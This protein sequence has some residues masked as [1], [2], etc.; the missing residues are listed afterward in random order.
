ME[1][2]DKIMLG[3]FAG[4]LILSMFAI[5]CYQYKSIRMAE[6]GYQ[7]VA[8]QGSQSTFWQKVK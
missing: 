6:L 1:S 7:E 2:I 8:Y 5:G 3:I 4:I